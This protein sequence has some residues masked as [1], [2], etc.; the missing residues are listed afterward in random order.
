MMQWVRLALSWG[1]F[2]AAMLAAAGCVPAILSVDDSV[3]VDS[4]PVTLVAY[5][6]R[7]Q[8]LG[9][10]SDIEHVTVSF[11]VD[12]KEIRR[13]DT[14]DGGRA[15]VE[16]PLP[17]QGISSF[18]VRAILDGRE[19][20]TTGTIFT[21]RENR[22]ILAIDI[23]NTIC[24]TEY[25]DLIFKTQDVES[26]PIPGS[27]E[28]L[29]D[30]SRDFYIAY[31]TA[32]PRIYVEKTRWWLNNNGFPAGPV[33]TT[34]RLRD[35]IKYKTLKRK[36]LANLRQRW[37]NLLI[38][39]GNNR[40]DADAYAANG[41]LAL[42]VHPTGK[43]AYGLHAIVLGDWTAIGRFFDLNHEVFVNPEELAK[44]ARGEIPIRRHVIAWR[45]GGED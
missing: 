34:P 18:G 13:A 7:A 35:M 24:R 39:I 23:D 15:V 44:T 22:P 21:W 32:R 43:H 31:V 20:Q 42:I 45:E 37:P 40:H 4:K 5:A 38:G 17:R 25:E 14:G 30:L 9:L 6:E 29:T 8:M 11:L 1:T 16:L 36:M 19:R 41:M 10:R 33:V 2:G 27:R 3:A 12:G 28:T 26:S